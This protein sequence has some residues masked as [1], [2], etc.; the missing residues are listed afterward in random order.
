MIVITGGNGEFGRLVAGH[1]LDHLP[2]GQVTVTAREPRKAG[3]LKD[4]GADVRHADFD[5]PATL[6]RA[7]RGAD[8]VLINGTNYGTD[9]ARR[10]Q[11][12]AAAITAAAESG[13]GRLV[14]TTWQDLDRCPMPEASDYPA[15]ETRARAAR[16]PVTIMRLTSDLAAAVARDVRWAVAAGTLTAPAGQARITPAAVT[17]LAEATANVLREAGHEGVTYELTGPTR[18]AGTISPRS[19]HQSAARTCA[20]SQSKTANT[21]S[22]SLLS[23]PPRRPSACCSTTTPPSAAAGPARPRVTWHS[24]CTGHRPARSRPSARQPRP[25]ASRVPSASHVNRDRARNRA[26]T[27]RCGTRGRSG[28]GDAARHPNRPPA[29]PGLPRQ[30]APA[31]DGTAP[32]GRALSST[33]ATHRPPDL[34]HR[35]LTGISP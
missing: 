35:Q 16:T 22:T 17:D 18:S 19:R 30:K 14:I 27:G 20:T 11:Q 26:S 21:G 29:G 15:T 1:L 9:P 33:A 25:S 31:R 12:H 5:E 34:P 13:A 23:A 4:R 7:F 10:A 8:T 32:A 24:S 28:S 3:P 2:A 6:V